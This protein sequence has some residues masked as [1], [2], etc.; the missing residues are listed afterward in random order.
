MFNSQLPKQQRGI[1]AIG[2]L[3]ILTF[4]AMV[5]YAGFIVLPIYLETT[6]VDAILEDVEKD[7]SGQ[8]TNI[9][10]IRNAIGKRLNI[11]SVTSVK[12]KDFVIKPVNRSL[13][14]GVAYDRE[15]L[16]AGNLYLL[17]K[18]NKT[19]EVSQ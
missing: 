8:P 11:E 2:M 1:T 4:V 14:V 6:K 19:V 5:G 10:S 16:Y 17:V 15:V 13:Q 3:V 9:G 7:F 12:T 18:Y